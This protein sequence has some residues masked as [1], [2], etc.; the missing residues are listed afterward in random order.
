MLERQEIVRQD[1]E[2]KGKMFYSGVM[3]VDI[4][5]VQVLY[6]HMELTAKV[7]CSPEFVQ[8]LNVDLSA[9][10]IALENIGYGPPEH[11]R[12]LAGDDEPILKVF[13]VSRTRPVC[14]YL[15]VLCM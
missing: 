3:G 5:A 1:C 14:E 13:F 10:K 4:K 15:V 7:M 6:P 12:F 2:E 8:T 11:V 9:G